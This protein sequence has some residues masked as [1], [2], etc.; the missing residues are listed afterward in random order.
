[1]RCGTP[2]VMEWTEAVTLTRPPDWWSMPAYY[3]KPTT[4]T[5]E[6]RLCGKCGYRTERDI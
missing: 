5:V 1:M 4:W 3:W 6:I 2:H